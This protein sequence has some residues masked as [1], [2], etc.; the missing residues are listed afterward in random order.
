MA[1]I[2]LITGEFHEGESLWFGTAVKSYVYGIAID[3]SSGKI[4]VTAESSGNNV[5]AM[6]YFK[7]DIDGSSLVS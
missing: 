6:F 1:K 7:M 4:V 3:Q 2:D 5:D